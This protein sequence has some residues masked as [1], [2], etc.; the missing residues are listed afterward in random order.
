MSTLPLY[1]NEQKIT[2]DQLGGFAYPVG[3]PELVQLML[4]HN[5]DPA[6]GFS[7]PLSK[8]FIYP[9][10]GKQSIYASRG[11]SWAPGQRLRAFKSG[12]GTA[13]LTILVNAYDKLTGKLTFEVTAASYFDVTIPNFYMLTPYYPQYVNTA[14]LPTAN[15]GTAANTVDNARTNLQL[16]T[17]S[18]YSTQFADFTLP[19]SFARHVTKTAGVLADLGPAWESILPLTNSYEPNN[20]PGIVRIDNTYTPAAVGNSDAVFFG[21]PFLHDWTDFSGAGTAFECNVN[22]ETLSAIAGNGYL[23]EIGLVGSTAKLL[24]SYADNVNSGRFV[25]SS[26][27]SSSFA[28]LNT[29]LTVAINTWYKIRIEVTGATITFKINDAQAQTVTAATFAGLSG[30]NRMSPFARITITNGNGSRAAI[31]YMM[32]R[33]NLSPVR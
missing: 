31:D 32:F 5:K 9:L 28:S 26:G 17:H 12:V 29:T 21:K 33:K 4:L 24:C 22:L 19:N 16:P 6:T 20:N 11:R 8:P 23:L 7:N 27:V 2:I 13:W 18:A 15:G 14:L 1:I 10:P 3:Y 25:Y 30:N